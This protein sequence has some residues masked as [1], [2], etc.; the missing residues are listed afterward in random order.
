ML[1]VTT[2][3]KYLKVTDGVTSKRIVYAN[4]FDITNTKTKVMFNNTEPQFTTIVGYT[5]DTAQIDTFDGSTSFT[6][7]SIAEAILAKVIA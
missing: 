1:T 7:D 3:A 4:I 6:A 2:A 5:L